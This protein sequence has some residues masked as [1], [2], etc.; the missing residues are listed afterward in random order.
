VCPCASRV[1]SRG[2]LRTTNAAV[3]GSGIHFPANEALGSSGRL[4]KRRWGATEHRDGARFPFRFL[5]CCKNHRKC[6]AEAASSL[7]RGEALI[8]VLLLSFGLW[9]AIWGAVVLLALSGGR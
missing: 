6:K 4:A 7:S 9:A 5:K 8:F 3:G 2:T 1:A